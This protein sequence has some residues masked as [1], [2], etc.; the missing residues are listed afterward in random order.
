MRSRLGAAD[1]DS[2]RNWSEIEFHLN[3][4]MC[5]NRRNLLV[6]KAP[7]S[8]NPRFGSRPPRGAYFFFGVISPPLNTRFHHR[9]FL[10]STL[11]KKRISISARGTCALC[12]LGES[13]EIV[14]SGR[15]WRILPKLSRSLA[16]NSPG[17]A[18]GSLLRNDAYTK[19]HPRDR[20][21]AACQCHEG[22]GCKPSS[23][24]N[25]LC[26][27]VASRIASSISSRSLWVAWRSIS[28]SGTAVLT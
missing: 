11:I 7:S 5:G 1:S 10:I 27:F 3:I 24:K 4:S 14:S 8:T 23:F 21:T 15:F 26:L 28:G 2:A 6:R 13:A 18:G 16:E 9:A 20:I 19:N 25:A 22:S 12:F 17:A